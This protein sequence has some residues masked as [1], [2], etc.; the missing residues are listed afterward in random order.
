MTRKRFIKLLM[1][2]GYSRDAAVLRADFLRGDRPYKEYYNAILTERLMQQCT[3][4]FKEISNA[5]K[6]LAFAVGQC[7]RAIADLFSSPPMQ[8]LVEQAVQKG[9]DEKS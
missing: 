9:K 2:E 5:F 8:A 3:V 7:L 6:E 4:Q 1:S